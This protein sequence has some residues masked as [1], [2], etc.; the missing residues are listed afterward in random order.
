MVKDIILV[1][2]AYRYPA[3]RAPNIISAMNKKKYFSFGDS[4]S[5]GIFNL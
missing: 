1:S 3:A 2:S 5:T 4:F